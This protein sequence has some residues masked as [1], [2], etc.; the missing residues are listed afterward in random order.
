MTLTPEVLV[1]RIGDTLVEQKLLTVEQ[2]N[3]AL[4]IQKQERSEGKSSLLG[5]V[6]VEHDFISQQ[7]LD[8]AITQQ[9]LQLHNALRQSNA[10]L[11]KRVK[12][13]TQELEIAYQKLSELAALK[14]NFVSN[15][16]H[17]LRTPL[18]H[19]KGYVNLLMEADFETLLPDQQ[20]ALTVIDKASARLGRMIEDLILFSTS[21]TSNLHITKKNIDVVKIARQVIENQKDQADAKKI[22][23]V[24]DSSSDQLGINSDGQLVFWVI[25]QLVDN[26]IKF[27]S[28]GGSILIGIH[29]V[30]QKIN[31][32]VADTG[33][34][35]AS[36][37][38]E[39]IFEPFHQLDESTTRLQGGTGLGL[40]LARKIIE[41][42]GSTLSVTS[43]LGKGS[44][45]QFSLER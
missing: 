28:T 22:S 7:V 43:T 4:S 38:L 1:P 23:L 16:S 20:H 12:D 30:D 13:R 37:K 17:E 25:N 9:I 5:Q 26:A 18:T 42:L 19:I 21:E 35:I 3:D 33:M 44:T 8:Q 41:A 2:L 6:L 29:A 40:T 31:V 27:T 14:A 15:I 45:F 39:E 32:I 10:T 24:L 34:G 11:E 36:G